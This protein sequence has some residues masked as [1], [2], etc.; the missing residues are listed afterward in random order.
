M[1][2]L[3]MKEQRN[4]VIKQMESLNAAA[5]KE[6]RKLNE[7]EEKKFAALESQKR[8]LD[9]AIE[10]I[11]NWK[12]QQKTAPKKNTRKYS[13]SK[14]IV[15]RMNHESLEDPEAAVDEIAA[16]GA[17]RTDS[18][19]IFL[20]MEKRA[21]LQATLASV[22]KEDVATDL[23]DLVTPLEN[24]LIATQAGATFLTGLQG[25]IAIPHY[26]GVTAGWAGEIEDAA[27]GAGKFKQETLVPKRITSYVDI[28]K[29]LL[30]QAND[31][32]ENYIQSALVNAV[33][34]TLEETMFGAEAGTD[35]KPAGLF[36]GVDS[37]AA[38]APTYGK[39]VDAATA[40]YKQNFKNLVWV[41][42]Y[43]AAGILKQT[44]KVAGQPFYLM[45]NGQIDGR[46]VYLSNN[47]T[48]KGLILGDFREL[49]IGQWGGIEVIVDPYTKALSGQ[50]RLIVNSYFNYYARKRYVNKGNDANPFA[51][52]ILK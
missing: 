14:A 38:A 30:I 9:T 52:L 22:G 33:R 12:A 8:G 42:S 49:T 32:I 13:F 36:S 6:E 24:E 48:P 11:E 28:S 7:D 21:V 27:D 51:K 50:V 23:L 35:V 2:V 15:A 26:S 10:T 39:L 47:V 5:K 34:E 44:P 19:S 3:E 46:T 1:T 4:S 40:L 18:N 45:E 41:A 31:S 16:R 17:M 37:A 25:D 43:D 29:Q 20:P